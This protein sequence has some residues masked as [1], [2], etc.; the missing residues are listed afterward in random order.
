MT[1]ACFA[2][3]AVELRGR[4][5]YSAKCRSLREREEEV[6]VTEQVSWEKRCTSVEGSVGDVM[7]R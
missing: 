6:L 7:I 1:P 3:A 5:E 4:K 2:K